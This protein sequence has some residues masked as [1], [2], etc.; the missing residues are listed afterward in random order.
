MGIPVVAVV[1]SNCDPELITYPIPGNDDAIRAVSFYCDLFARAIIDGLQ[2]ELAASGADIGEALEAPTEEIPAADA[3]E[4]VAAEAVE[5][6][7]KVAPEVKTETAAEAEAESQ[8]QPTEAQA[9]DTP[10]ANP[11]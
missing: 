1:D 8:E 7:A 2:Q 3:L 10:A 9:E 5:R 11:A 4:N 6:E